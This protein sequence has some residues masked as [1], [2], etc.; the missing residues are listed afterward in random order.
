M[1]FCIDVISGCPA[2]TETLNFYLYTYIIRLIHRCKLGALNESNIFSF[3]LCTYVLLLTVVVLERDCKSFELK[4]GVG[5]W[6]IKR[7]T[8]YMLLSFDGYSHRRETNT[9]FA[10]AKMHRRLSNLFFFFGKNTNNLLG[11]MR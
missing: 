7:W 4:K 11:P 5:F 6:L 2:I 10:W 9:S 1:T 3:F 8:D